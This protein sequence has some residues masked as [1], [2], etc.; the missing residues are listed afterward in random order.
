MA[1]IIMKFIEE[2]MKHKSEEEQKRDY[3]I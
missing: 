1:D 3:K 2:N